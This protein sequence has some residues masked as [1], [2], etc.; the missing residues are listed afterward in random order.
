MTGSIAAARAQKGLY[1]RV[2]A[3]RIPYSRKN[4]VDIFALECARICR[5]EQAA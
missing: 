2:V 5:G 4:C 3:F 1:L